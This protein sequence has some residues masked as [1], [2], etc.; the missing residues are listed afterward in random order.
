MD[1]LD[2]IR[3]AEQ[4]IPK[5]ILYGTISGILIK[6][7][8]E[9]QVD[10][11]ARDNETPEE[12]AH[13]I[14][15]SLDDINDDEPLYVEAHENISIP[16]PFNISKDEY[17]NVIINSLP[18]TGDIIVNGKQ[19]NIANAI[20][21]IGL[22]DSLNVE[23]IIR[24]YKN[25]LRNE[26]IKPTY[27]DKQEIVK[28][29]FDMLEKA[30]PD[31]NDLLLHDKMFQSEF[32]S[33]TKLLDDNLIINIDD[34]QYEVED[35]LNDIYNKYAERRYNSVTSNPILVEPI[36]IT[37][38]DVTSSYI[39]LGDDDRYSVINNINTR[40]YNDELRDIFIGLKN[41][42]DQTI[43][44]YKNQIDNMK[45]KDDNLLSK[46]N[47]LEYIQ[48]L[49]N[50]EA[51]SENRD[52]LESRIE[53]QQI[54]DF[55]NNIEL[56]KRDYGRTCTLDDPNRLTELYQ[57][58]FDSRK[59]SYDMG[60]NM[61]TEYDGLL[62]NVKIIKLQS[63]YSMNNV[64]HT[65]ESILEDIDAKLR[66]IKGTLRYINNE[67]D[68]AKRTGLQAR[69]PGLMSD[70]EKIINDNSRNFT[71]EEIDELKNKINQAV[72]TEEESK[73]RVA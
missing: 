63:N 20:R 65:K 66:A 72:F 16:Y 1:K 22:D 44:L 61:A 33:I 27:I 35:Y 3:K 17:I 10:R 29:S 40:D 45:N 48:R 32:A 18:Y 25:V 51:I 37:R 60:I 34:K 50:A 14:K 8:I 26:T 59:N 38:G 70:C 58:I 19:I 12:L 71:V 30:H 73:R 6:D 23:P 64:N 41:A 21:S 54:P 39:F 57:D 46:K 43:S 53:Y 49:R 9:S 4:F 7:F 42:N 36:E 55:K 28:A 68:I 5:D 47:T 24:W 15:F 69:I 31:L 2:N 67:N 56:L 13:R 52:D 11:I 62:N